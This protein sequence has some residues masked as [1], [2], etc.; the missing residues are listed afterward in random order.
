MFLKFNVYVPGLPVNSHQEVK[1]HL[2]EMSLDGFNEGLKAPLG[3]LEDFVFCFLSIFFNATSRL[4]KTWN[5]NNEGE[6]IITVVFKI[7]ETL[8]DS[9]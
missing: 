4:F 1:S 2:A 7:A 3:L 5:N 9:D 6:A 8:W